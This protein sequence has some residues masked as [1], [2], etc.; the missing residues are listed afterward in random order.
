MTTPGRT[1]KA[2]PFG[3]VLRGGRPRGGRPDWRLLGITVTSVV[4]AIGLGLMAAVAVLVWAG[5]QSILR[6]DV[7]GLRSAQDRDGLMDAEHVEE[8]DEVLNVLVVGSDS[9]EGLTPRQL[10]ALGTEEE[11]GDRTDTII[12]A[13]LD[14]GHGR[15]ELLS[16]PRDLLVTRCDGSRG[17]INEA[18]QIGEEQRIGGPTCLVQTVRG[19][20]SV[21]IDHFVR[22]NLAGF[23]DVVDAVGGVSFYL[24]EPIR[25]RH[26]GVDLP[27]GCVT[28]DGARAVGF[29]R[30][31]YIDSDLGRIARQQRFIRELAR[32]ATSA[33]TILQPQKLFDVVR[34]VGRTLETD[35]GFGLTQMRQI[36]YTFRDLEAERITMWTVPSVESPRRVA[37]YLELQPEQAAALFEAFRTGDF[38]SSGPVLPASSVAREGAA[39][40]AVAPPGGGYRGSDDSIIT[41]G[42]A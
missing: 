1:R 33:G 17:R 36:A 11:E 39:P 9:R 20:T 13:R 35:R 24:D 18:Y 16:F 8:I 22:I 42:A 37:S 14:P 25:D 26:A 5:S 19:L 29:V 27:A 3:P 40:L 7:W 21:P 38:S 2:T 10:Q 6:I 4:T 34:S 15:A 30:A 41:C 28:L 12:L 31:R 23:I 32:K